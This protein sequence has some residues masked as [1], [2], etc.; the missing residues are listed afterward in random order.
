[1]KYI[2]TKDARIID[3]ERK[4]LYN[5]PVYNFDTKENVLKAHQNQ[6]DRNCCCIDNNIFYDYYYEDGTLWEYEIVKQ[7]DTVEELV[8]CYSYETETTTDLGV[9]LGWKFANQ[10][11]HI[12]GCIKTDKGLIYVAKMNDEGELEL[13]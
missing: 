6:E 13:L 11:R 7:A 10:S 9:A 1:M 5:L 2:R 12:Y 3:L 8:D 4:G